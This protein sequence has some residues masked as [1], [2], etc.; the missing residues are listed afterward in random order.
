MLNEHWLNTTYKVIAAVV[1]LFAL[2]L[3]PAP[4]L[5]PHRLA[6][7]I[8]SAFSVSWKA[9]YLIAAIGLQAIFFGSIGIVSPFLLTK[10]TTR[11]GRLMQLSIMPIVIVLVALTIRSLKMG[12]LPVWINA[13]IPIIACCIGVWLGMGLLYQRGKIMFFIM[14]A[15]IGATFWLLSGG[16]PANLGRATE[17][18]LKVLATTDSIIP[19]GEE[20]F[21]A[22]LKKAFAP[23]PGE[24]GNISA[25]EQNRAAILALGIALGDEH[26]SR[27]V[28]LK[29]DSPLVHQAIL[30]R[31][32][33]TL[34]DRTDW[35]RHYCLSAAL[36]VLENPMVS[37]AGGLMKEQLDALTRG[38]G[39]SFGDF[40]ADRAGVRFANA[41]T[42][43]EEDARAMQDLIK[44]EFTIGNFL[45]V[46]NDLPENMTTEQFRSKFGSVGSKSFHRI[47]LEIEKRLDQC[48]ALSPLASRH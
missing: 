3:V 9:A 15:V 30:L 45:P 12:H 41:A 36:A 19:S 22:L 34:Q 24:P 14:I 1:I 16:P 35:T 20:R 28:G 46:I 17:N 47:L 2:L 33:T 7:F 25:I 10:N 32:G 13:V 37:D 31:E 26:I 48:I 18:H 23:L 6:E 39:F 40:A 11:R 42:N 44:S 5:P 8:E 29:Q 27:F 4:L 21:R 38:S 43:S